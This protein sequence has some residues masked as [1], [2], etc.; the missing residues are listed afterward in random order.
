[1]IFSIDQN[2]HSLWDTLPKLQALALSGE[3][4][5]H[6][7]EDVD[8]AFTDIGENDESEPR[9]I[10]ERHYPSG[11]TDWGASLFYHEFL[12][13]QPLELRRLEPQL[14]S[15][16]RCGPRHSR[17]YLFS[18]QPSTRGQHQ[19]CFVWRSRY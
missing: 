3:K 7:V 8:V 18:R 1:M 16:Y 15:W 19:R 14:G 9:I 17:S 5:T 12:G 4:I 6:F 2:S 11:G 13:R 10:R